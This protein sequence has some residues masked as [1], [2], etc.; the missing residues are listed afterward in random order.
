MDSNPNQHWGFESVSKS[1]NVSKTSGPI[2]PEYPAFSK[3]N[4]AVAIKNGGRIMINDP[5]ENSVFD[6]KNGDEITVEAMVQLAELRGQAAILTKGRTNNPGVPTNNQNWAF[7]IKS[8][9]RGTAGVNFLFRSRDDMDHKSDWHR[10][11]STSGFGI[12]AGWHHVAISYRFGEPDS[13]RGYIDGKP[14]KGKWDLGGPTQVAPV[15]DNDEVWIGSSMGGNL[16]NSLFGAV[17]E[18][19]L[20]RRIV[21]A[22]VISKRYERV[23]P[24]LILPEPRSGHL[25]ISIHPW[26]EKNKLPI[27][28]KPA[29][30]Q[31]Q[32]S[33]LGFVRLPRK[34]DNWG[35]RDDWGTGVL[36]RAVTAITLEPGEYEFLGRSRG[37]ARLFVD[38]QKIM[39]FPPVRRGGGAHNQV[40]P[41]PEVPRKGMRPHALDDIEK[42]V[43][44][45][46]SGG[47]HSIVYDVMVGGPRLRLEFGEGCLAIAR[48]GEMFRLVGPTAGPELTDTGWQEFFE[49]TSEW[50][51]ARDRMIRRKNDQ[52]ANYWK[53]RHQLAIEQLVKNT[54]GE[55]RSIDHIVESRI[56]RA[57]SGDADSFFNR[58]VQPLL[59]KH[60][61]RCHGEKEKGDLNLR[62]QKHLF[63]EGASGDP[64]VVPG[65]PGESHLLYRV[66]LEAEAERMPPTGDGLSDD[67]ISILKKWIGN[68]GE[69]EP[70]PKT[71]LPIPPQLDDL[72]FLRRAWID[73]VGVAPPLDVVK[74]FQ[75]DSS[76]DKRSRMIDQ[77]LKDER[78]ADNWMGYWQD[79]LAEN[80]NLLK[81]NLNNTGPF[82]YWILEA[83]QDNKP[84]DRFA[85]ELITMRG[86]VWDGGAAGFFEASQNDVPMAAKA[87]IIGTAFLGVELKCARCHDAPYHETTQ[88]DVFEI[89]AML[90]RKPIKLPSTSSVPKGF[91]E[92][93]AKGGREP[94][95]EASLNIGETINPRWPFDGLIE[96]LPQTDLFENLDSREQLAA[97]ITFS[98]RFAEV[99]VNRVW[100]RLMGA[101]LVESVDDWEGKRPSD[102]ELL[103]RL[104]DEF[105]R[106]GYDLKA[107]TRFIM[108]SELYQRQAIDPPSNF[109]ESDRL[110]E[111]PYRRRMT[112]EQVVDNAWHVSGKTMDLGWL[113]MDREGRLKPGFFMN[114]GQP[115]KAWEFTTLANER[116][117]PSLAMPRMQA[118][119]DVLLAFGWR[120]SRQEPTSQRNEAPNPLQPGV[121]ANGVMGGWLTRLTDESE[122]TKM[123]V[124]A[125]SVEQLTEDLFLRYLTRIP[126]K[127]ERVAFESLLQ[128]GLEDRLAPVDQQR[129]KQEPKRYPYVSWSNHLDNEAN[130]IKQ[131]QEADAR[132]GDPPTR[133]L[134]DAWR[135]NA[136]DALW[137]LLNSPEMIL[138]P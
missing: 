111:G 138:I 96:A 41:I 50:L 93:V 110:F 122:I 67:E 86:S 52:Q 117:R 53:Q 130:T 134:K 39:D 120:N 119:V 70:E 69:I 85:T 12:N 48:K 71:I 121:L 43:T 61:Y 1:K 56:A 75:K 129:A 90:E 27:N 30:D 13:I 137:A 73:V 132:R 114:F 11:T 97:Q 77:L 4:S 135:K 62:N 38:G 72:N 76:A 80:P 89:A 44:F 24:E 17:D 65:Q 29:L 15:V 22:S 2:S 49:Q 74:T 31:W 47:R 92:H 66:S 8:T 103:E 125:S 131:Q 82:R 58:E 116:D 55:N 83:L 113:T 51:D 34:Y 64:I 68:G 59:A 101:G 84:M 14:V 33:A 95:I 126:T 9:S 102:P 123:C 6:F 109:A 118:V 57:E 18:I 78:W 100:K 128:N 88:R 133:Y 45:S 36:V 26:T 32:Q 98:R 40:K 25:E 19:A 99:I 81:P 79:V 10:W 63:A 124:E 107:L 108:N 104:S 21:P 115:K 54:G 127:N 28:P 106:S 94:L 5:G 105:I 42:I 7:R 35:V 37:V 46:S 20:Y 16:G 112:A 23:E 87:H 91:F 136:E 3:V 60:C